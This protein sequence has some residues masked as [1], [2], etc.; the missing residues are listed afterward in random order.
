VS[1]QYYLVLAITRIPCIL[2]FAW[3]K[4]GR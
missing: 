1:T 2:F 3:E 4:C